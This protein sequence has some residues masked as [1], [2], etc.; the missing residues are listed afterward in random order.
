[1]CFLSHYKKYCIVVCN[2]H[3]VA[4]RSESVHFYGVAFIL[5]SDTFLMPKNL[6]RREKTKMSDEAKTALCT[7]I[8]AVIS[9]VV[10]WLVA[11]KN[12]PL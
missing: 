9:A 4:T 8:A 5:E 3:C 6:K 12:N 10:S 2:Y 1:M 11:K 7:L